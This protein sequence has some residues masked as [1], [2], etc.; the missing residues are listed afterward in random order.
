MAFATAITRWLTWRQWD[1]AC[2]DYG[3]REQKLAAHPEC[4]NA[5]GSQFTCCCRACPQCARK[6]TIPPQGLR[7]DPQFCAY[8]FA[9]GLAPP[10]G[11]V[12]VHTA[13]HRRIPRPNQQQRTAD[14]APNRGQLV[15]DMGEVIDQAQRSAFGP[16]RRIGRRPWDL[17]GGST[18]PSSQ[19][20]PDIGT[21]RWN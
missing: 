14:S 18:P 10:E 4:R 2:L 11:N 9:E 5:T 17:A 3:S 13:T 6:W 16:Q 12:R 1:C 8:C 7:V 19:Q 21:E 15:Q 20:L